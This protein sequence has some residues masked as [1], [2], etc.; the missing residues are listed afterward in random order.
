M[1]RQ[2]ECAADV[3]PHRSTRFHGIGSRLAETENIVQ[4]IQ[5]GIEI[6]AVGAV[7]DVFARNGRA[8]IRVFGFTLEITRIVFPFD[9]SAKVD[10][11]GVEG[12]ALAHFQYAAQVECDAVV[13]GTQFI[14][15]RIQC[16]IETQVG[17][18]DSRND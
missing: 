16:D 6:E 8:G 1:F 14:A 13:F 17:G 10:H 3:N 7:E 12:K 15:Q 2:F 5:F 11:T 9:Q 4:R 18:I